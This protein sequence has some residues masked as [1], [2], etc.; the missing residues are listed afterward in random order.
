MKNIKKTL[1]LN[2]LTIALAVSAIALGT[3]IFFQTLALSRLQDQAAANEK[4]ISQIAEITNQINDKAAERTQQINQLSSRIDCIAQF[5]TRK[6]RTNYVIADIDECVLENTSSGSRTSL[7]LTALPNQTPRAS[8]NS[9]STGGGSAGG[10]ASPTPNTPS[11]PSEAPAQGSF[12]ERNILNPIG[13]NVVK[14]V[15]NFLT[16]LF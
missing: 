6:D 4:I 15:T 7:P 9:G 11:T 16:N 8:E 14:P 10:T 12:L 2:S 13:E 1:R 5:F 3:I